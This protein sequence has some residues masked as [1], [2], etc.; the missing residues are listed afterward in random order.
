[1]VAIALTEA[2]AGV[3]GIAGPLPRLAITLSD[4]ARAGTRPV[5]C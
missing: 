3:A 1:M 2:A 4:L 5:P